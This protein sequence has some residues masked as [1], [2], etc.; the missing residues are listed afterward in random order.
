MVD[1]H[2]GFKGRGVFPS[3]VE[4]NLS[5]RTA[6]KRRCNFYNARAV[7][8]E[9]AGDCLAYRKLTFATAP[10]ALQAAEPWSLFSPAPHDTHAAMRQTSNA[11]AA[12]H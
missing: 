3:E 6:P 7:S 11:A 9:A 1:S 10:M 5:R 2:M 4:F 12:S 8:L